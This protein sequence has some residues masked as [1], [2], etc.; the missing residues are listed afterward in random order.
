MIHVLLAAYNE[1][2]A[3]GRVLE[4]TAGALA[5]RTFRVWVVDDG[6]S[7]RTAAVAEEWSGR[8][9]LTLL[10]HERNGGLGQTL[11]TGLAAAGPALG[12]DDALVTLDADDTQPPALIPVLTEPLAAGR[13]D[14]AIASR[15]APG[16][17]SVGVPWGRRMASRGAALLFGAVFG[18]PGVRDY[19]CGFRAYR[20]SLIR[21]GTER[22]GGLVTESGF[23]AGLEWLIKLSFLKPRVVEVPLVLRYDKKP[24]PSKMP[25][26]RT[27]V[28]TLAVL[29]RLRKYKA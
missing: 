28:R 22:W 6:S 20:G 16:G 24:T 23:A 18:I 5:G 25:V 12:D 17:K 19:T 9:P 4:E 27:I 7:D 13:A 8:L 15:F 26:G 10:R 11:R 2:E 3:L 14:V 29:A 1:E 21:R